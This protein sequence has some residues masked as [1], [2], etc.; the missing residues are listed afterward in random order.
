MSP[1]VSRRDGIRADIDDLFASARAVGEVLEE[2]A[3]LGVRPLTQS[4]IGP[5]SATSALVDG[6]GL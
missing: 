4:A 6:S 5:C 2:V 3:G 1:R